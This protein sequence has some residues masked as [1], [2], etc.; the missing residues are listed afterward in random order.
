ME[1]ETTTA[2]REI[3]ISRL[4]NAPREL[5]FKVWTD[6]NHIVHW[7]GP[8]GFK[9]TIHDMNVKTGG[10]WNFIM[11]GPD[12]VDYPNKI[13]Y[14]EVTIPER[15]VYDHSGDD[16]EASFSVTVTFDE[17]DGKTYLTMRSLFKTKEER[18]LVIK[19][20]GAMEG[21]KQTLNHLEEYLKNMN[22]NKLFQK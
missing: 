2:D 12:G 15:L 22:N 19:D 18:D 13:V 4:I 1:K 8:N 6:P 9:N 16:G 3:V 5:V 11:H 20:H 21:G 10:E 17:Q 14:K 7:W